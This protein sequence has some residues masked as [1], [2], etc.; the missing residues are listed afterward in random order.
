MS[1][2]SRGGGS[3][4]TRL[5]ACGI[6]PISTGE[7]GACLANRAATSVT[8]A[9]RSWEARTRFMP[10][11]I[12]IPSQPG[13]PKQLSAALPEAR[14]K[15]LKTRHA[16]S[17]LDDTL[18]EAECAVCVMGLE[19]ADELVI[20]LPCGGRHMYH[21]RCLQPWFDKASICPTCRGSLKLKKAGEL[22][23]GRQSPGR[24][25]G[26]ADSTRPGPTGAVRSSS[27]PR[28]RPPSPPKGKARASLT[29]SRHVGAK[30]TTV[31]MHGFGHCRFQPAP[32]ATFGSPSPRF[33]A[34]R[35]GQA[36]SSSPGAF[37]LSGQ[38]RPSSTPP[39]RIR[40][41]A[42]RDY[43]ILRQGPALGGREAQ[44]FA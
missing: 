16:V 41:R 23:P 17:A 22:S 6:L 42:Q 1:V 34:M 11:T 25:P 44:E 24:S 26:P 27:S 40:S 12:S 8:A 13:Q 10:H 32:A 38:A 43:D 7:S 37:S 33:S 2:P 19:P 4:V 14:R 3:G 15:M 9:D 29:D 39:V 21:W 31:P 35:T 5:A 30:P 18:D 20:R 36:A 28:Q